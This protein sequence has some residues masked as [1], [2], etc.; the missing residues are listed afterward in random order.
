MDRKPEDGCEIKDSCC[1]KSNILMRLKLV[2]TP[3]EEEA[4][5]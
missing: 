4:A 2:K 3:S 1:G 5:R